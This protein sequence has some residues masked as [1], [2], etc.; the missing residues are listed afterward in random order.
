MA[1]GKEDGRPAAR[2]QAVGPRQTPPIRFAA[3]DES[4]F[5]NSGKA[6]KSARAAAEDAAR[7]AGTLARKSKSAVKQRAKS[8][9]RTWKGL[10][11][12]LL[13]RITL[14][15]TVIAAIFNCSSKPFAFDWSTKDDRAVCRGLAQSKLHLQPI[16]AP[17]YAQLQEK[18]EPYVK[19]VRP[20]AKTV[21]KHSKP[22]VKKVN[23]TGY[24]VYK[25]H[26][27]PVQRRS[28]NKARAFAEPHINV[29]NAKYSELVQPRIDSKLSSAM[30]Y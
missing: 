17:Y 23:K 3:E 14:F 13:V 24:A 9:S 21:W 28:I 15:Y 27:L 29:A 6:L 18:A 7:K 8:R 12:A 5:K 19:V 4:N 25:K 1:A 26:V 20:Y 10:F 30:P 22:V 11:F 16:I 2:S